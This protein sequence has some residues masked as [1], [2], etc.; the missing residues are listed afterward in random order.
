[1]DLLIEWTETAQRDSFLA[2]RTELKSNLRT[3][4]G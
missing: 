1:M 2:E 4:A 3:T